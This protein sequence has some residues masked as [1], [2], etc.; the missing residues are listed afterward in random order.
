[1][2]RPRIYDEPRVVT[3]V[4]LPAPLREELQTV[5]GER[6]VSIN[7]LVVRAVEKYLQNLPS[8]DFDRG[9]QGHFV[10]RPSSEAAR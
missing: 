6:E 1:M 9:G 3:A 2:G 4:R 7:Y 5:A 10:L 8:V